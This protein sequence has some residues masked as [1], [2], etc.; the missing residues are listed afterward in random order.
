MR[1][2]K[3]AEELATVLNKHINNKENPEVKE[4]KEKGIGY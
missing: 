3:L 2:I 1:A 4:L